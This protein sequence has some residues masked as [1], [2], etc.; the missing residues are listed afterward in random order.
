FTKDGMKAF[1]E[2]ARAQY[3][4]GEVFST[5]GDEAAARQHWEAAARGVDNYPQPDAVYVFLAAGRIA[6]GREDERRARLEAALD[7]WRNRAAVGTNFPGP[8]AAGQGQFLH[9]LGREEEARAKL[10]E[11]LLLPDKV[12]SHYLARAALASEG[13]R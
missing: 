11:A 5:C 9:A 1:V 3:L 8:N 2:G 12:M 7:S 13:L 6:A 4:V 10:R